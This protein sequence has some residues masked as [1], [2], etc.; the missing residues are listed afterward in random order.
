VDLEFS[1]VHLGVRFS[2]MQ[3]AF[4]SKTSMHMR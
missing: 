2:V 1:E 4:S 3:V